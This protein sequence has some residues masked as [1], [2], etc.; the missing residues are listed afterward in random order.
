MLENIKNNLQYKIKTLQFSFQTWKNAQEITK[1]YTPKHKKSPFQQIFKHLR[2]AGI[3][4]G[5]TVGAVIAVFGI[6]KI[7][8]LKPISYPEAAIVPKS[9]DKSLPTITSE[10]ILSSSIT[11]PEIQP[12][13]KAPIIHPESVK[14]QPLKDYFIIV[15]NK[16]SRMMYLL[17]NTTEGWTV[18]KTYKIA[19]GEQGGQKQTAGDKRTPEGNYFILSRKEKREL[20]SIYGPLAY[21]LDYP[22]K[23]DSKAGRTGQGIWIHGTE[24]DSVPG[25]TKGCLELFN[26]DL[27][28]LSTFL[29][30]GTGTPVIII[31]SDENKDPVKIPDYALI[32]ERRH[33]SFVKNLKSRDIFINLLSDWELAWE[34]RDISKYREFYDTDQFSGQ[35][36]R[37]NAW[38]ERKIRTFK[39]Y[40]KIDIGINRIVVADL[41]DSI[42]VIKFVQL[43]QSDQN[44]LENGKKLILK[45]RNNNWKI[46]GEETIPKEE[47]LL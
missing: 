4:L 46:I 28:E 15:A 47:L 5:I 33:S 16:A 1:A 18:L 41:A 10:S 11:P 39:I 40:S 13:T 43:Y 17:Q 32:D 37:W 14:T 12:V 9:P 20:T 6:V 31:N 3:S 22:N 34:S 26:K 2:T 29:K 42:A 23:E 45:K 24:P 36:V 38:E 30:D 25:Q 27:E 35:G 21:V 44:S 19:T 7:I 8:Q